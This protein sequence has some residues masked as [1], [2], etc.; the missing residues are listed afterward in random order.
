M[1]KTIFIAILL[2]TFFEG[3]Y[4]Q[5]INDKLISLARI[6]NTYRTVENPAKDLVKDIRKDSPAQLQKTAEFIIQSITP[7]NHLLDIQYLTVPDESTL[8]YIYIINSVSKNLEDEN[9]RD[10][11]DLVNELIYSQISRYLEIDAYYGILFSAIGNKS[12]PS[13]HSTFDF[14]TDVYNLSDSTEKGVFFLRCMDQCCRPIHSLLH[15]V[16]PADTK[17]AYR[18][19]KK[20]P[21]FDGKPYFCFTDFTFPDFGVVISKQDGLR[22]FKTYYMTQ[23]Y[24]LLLDHLRCLNKQGGT[25]KEK[26]A[27][28][29]KSIL[30]DRTLYKY[31][32]KQAVLNNM[33]Y[34]TDNDSSAGF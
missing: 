9:P 34:Y 15:D 1:K 22:S 23:Y 25:D 7:K 12:K 13:S 4:S 33:F 6:Y 11:N 17:F 20:M 19:L 14:N 18:Y 2:F 32:K 5:Q 29:Y 24:D 3:V 31:S 28:L 10:N 30:K 8:K 27:L 26:E 16:Q 21:K